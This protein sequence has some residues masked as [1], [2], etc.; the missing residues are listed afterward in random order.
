MRAACAHPRRFRAK[1]LRPSAASHAGGPSEGGGPSPGPAAVYLLRARASFLCCAV[2]AACLRVSREVVTR[3]FSNSRLNMA[4]RSWAR[5][6][7]RRSPTISFCS[8]SARSRSA[9]ALRWAVRESSRSAASSPVR[10]L[11]RDP[12]GFRCS[13]PRACPPGAR[14][15]DRHRACAPMDARPCA[16]GC[17]QRRSRLIRRGHAP[18]AGAEPRRPQRAP[19]PSSSSDICS[20]CAVHRCA[21]G[22]A[23][24]KRRIAGGEIA[25]SSWSCRRAA[26]SSACRAETC[27]AS[28]VRRAPARPVRRVVPAVCW[29]FVTPVPTHG[30]AVAGPRQAWRRTLGR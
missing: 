27:V 14:P 2:C 22:R 7:R 8:P 10:A 25:A 12:R 23:R 28:A 24:R 19:A 6:S 13:R 30:V 11:G 21:H 16:H 1:D 29:P 20:P 4:R 26:S 9:P 3:S 17:A 18:S 15:A 5:S